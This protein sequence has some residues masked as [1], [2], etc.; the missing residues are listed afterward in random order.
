[1]LEH[2]EREQRA[3]HPRGGDVDPEQA[4]DE[5]AIELQQ[6]VYV[7][8]LDLVRRHRRGSLRD[9]A[10]V[11]V[12]AQVLDRAVLADLQLHAQLI[13][14]QRVDVLELEVRIG[15]LAPVVGALVVAEDLLAVQVVHQPNTF[16]TLASAS[17]SASTSS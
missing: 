5:L 14:A 3:L 6:L 4:E 12:E 2:L 16:W 17:I 15:E 9:R 1:A 7:H 13:A 8:A 11:P 10:A